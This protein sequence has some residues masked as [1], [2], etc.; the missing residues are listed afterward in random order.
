ME[1]LWNGDKDKAQSSMKLLI[2]THSLRYNYGGILQNFALQQV[3][4]RW[5]MDVTTLKLRRKIPYMLFVWEYIKYFIRLCL[6]RKSGKPLKTSDINQ[7]CQETDIFI[8]K[9]IKMSPAMNLIDKL[10]IR[11]QHFDG[12]IVGSD[13]VLHP[14]SY[15]PIEDI[16]LS[17]IDNVKKIIYAGSFGFD[18]W[19][20][21]DRQTLRCSKLLKDFVGIS[22]REQ[23][24]VHFFSE[25]LG[26]SAEL[27]LDPTL[28]LLK[29]DYQR[30]VD[31]A[32]QTSGLVTYILD[33]CEYKKEIIS[34][35]SEQ[36]HLDIVSASNEHMDNPMSSPGQ[37]KANSV[38][39]WLTQLFNSEYI[40]T[41]SFHGT[42]FAIIFEKNFVTIANGERGLDRFTTL[43]S[44]L[45]LE[46]R[47][48][49][50]VSDISISQ[51][52]PIDYK[53]VNSVIEP[54]RRHSLSFLN[55]SIN[56]PL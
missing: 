52:E 26:F 1:S 39:S 8:D 5:D 2:I 19:K 14:A 22:S 44:R 23:K 46:N 10:W 13:Q 31:K 37:R 56:Q 51:F 12:I 16:Y 27:V 18:S 29:E 55:E 42:C 53:R 54:L 24:G 41:D 25:N 28:L 4:Q 9:Y 21:T 11:N 17:F 32:P 45:G 15:S 35:I 34:R 20:Y 3:L 47:L 40:V 48:V 36:L 30:F 50:S 33:Q 49:Y 38:E 7:I 6:G 43:L